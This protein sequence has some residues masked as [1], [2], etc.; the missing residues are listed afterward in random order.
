L[1]AADFSSN[2]SNSHPLSD[3]ITY[4]KYKIKEKSTATKK[5]NFYSV[6]WLLAHDLDLLFDLVHTAFWAGSGPAS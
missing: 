5:P 4:H 3:F 2:S 6:H 1:V